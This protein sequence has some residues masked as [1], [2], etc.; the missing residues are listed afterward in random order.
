MIPQTPSEGSWEHCSPC[1]G[2]GENLLSCRSSSEYP[3]ATKR[4]VQRASEGDGVVAILAG[5]AERPAG[6]IVEESEAAGARARR[7]VCV[8]LCA[9]VCTHTHVC[10]THVC[11]TFA[12]L[13]VCAHVCMKACMCLRARVCTCMQHMCACEGLCVCVHV[14]MHVCV[15]A[16]AGGTPG[17]P[18]PV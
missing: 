2:L 5:R 11:T 7:L 1:R 18:D 6:L 14:C 17:K 12:C 15:E 16:E 9:R 8:C 10:V 4:R 3:C 13:H